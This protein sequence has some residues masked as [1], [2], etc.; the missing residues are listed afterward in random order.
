MESKSMKKLKYI[1]LLILFVAIFQACTP[2]PATA[3]TDANQNP[4]SIPQGTTYTS[5][6]PILGQAPLTISSV[7][8][9][10]ISVSF[11][12]GTSPAA[13]LSNYGGQN[14]TY[15]YRNGAMMATVSLSDG[16]SIT[17]TISSLNNNIQFELNNVVC[18][19]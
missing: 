13:I 19:R 7:S 12:N 3:I 10:S 18:N 16:D 6:E 8:V 5:S 9:R 2:T 4:I 15:L 14:G 17:V 1:I 11:G